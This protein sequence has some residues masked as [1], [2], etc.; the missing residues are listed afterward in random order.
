MRLNRAALAIALSIPAAFLLLN[1][2]NKDSTKPAVN[3][4]AGD[5]V[6]IEAESYTDAHDTAGARDSTLHCS[7]AS[8]FLAVEGVDSDGDW[9]QM[10]FTLEDRT[11]F[12]DSLRGEGMFGD[13]RRFAVQFYMG[14]ALVASDT[15]VTPPGNGFG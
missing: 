15:L 11:C 4:P 12:S 6:R 7:G 14:D 3:P 2:C 9:I 1:G 13:V 5:T 10:P 8:G